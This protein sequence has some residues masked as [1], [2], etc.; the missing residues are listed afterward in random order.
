MQGEL[1]CFEQW[2]VPEK[3][4]T[5]PQRK[6]LPSGGGGE[7]KMF[8]I[9]VSVLGHPKGVA[10]LQINIWLDRTFVRSLLIL[11]GHNL[12]L[13]GQK[14]TQLNLVGH[15]QCIRHKI[16]ISH[17]T[18]MYS[19]SGTALS[20]MPRKF[21]CEMQIEWICNRIL[22]Q[23]KMYS[24]TIFFCDRTNVRSKL[25]L[26]GHLPNLVGH[27]PMSDSNLQPWGRGVN[28]QFPPWGWYGCFLEWAN[29]LFVGTLVSF[30]QNVEV[31][32]YL[33]L[34]YYH[35]KWPSFLNNYYISRLESVVLRWILY[36][37]QCKR[38]W[39]NNMQKTV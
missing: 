20:R 14:P 36:L 29:K 15:I 10:G 30:A 1:Q 22:S 18:S 28:I 38:K 32:L 23:Q 35:P 33:L 37:G 7:K 25:L 27:C 17:E 5:P 6:F 12:N 3:I 9:I 11:V 39:R 16:Y 21:Y 2:V 24:V 4:H 26:L 34:Q 19:H 13:V 8:L 31:S